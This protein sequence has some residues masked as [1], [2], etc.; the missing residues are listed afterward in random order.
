MSK[1]RGMPTAGG[2]RP[3]LG[4]EQLAVAASTGDLPTV[5]RLLAEGVSPDGTPVGHGRTPL[6][7]AAYTGSLDV[8]VALL[9]AG[10]D[11][12]LC[13]S[14]G[15]SPLAIVTDVKLAQ[16][17]LAAGADPN[18][19]DKYR[20]TPLMVHSAYGDNRLDII[21]LLLDHGARVSWQG[22]SKNTALHA[23]VNC[24]TCTANRVIARLIDAGA[25]PNACNDDGF[26]PLHSVMLVSSLTQAFLPSICALLEAG[27]PC[28]PSFS[29]PHLTPVPLQAPTATSSREPPAST[30]RHSSCCRA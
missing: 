27:T 13:N 18:V 28:T 24:T 25:D 20:D 21:N 10:A 7:S 3:L 30:R 17:L 6:I 11:P 23:S 26:T 16:H 4:A 9:D 29:T 14:H 2:R 22:K 19:C 8:L 5:K 1:P 12:N 15:I